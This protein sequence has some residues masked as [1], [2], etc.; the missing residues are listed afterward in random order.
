MQ[1]L[2]ED[3]YGHGA[4]WDIEVDEATRLECF[5]VLFTGIE[6]IERIDLSGKTHVR[7]K[8]TRMRYRAMFRLDDMD[9]IWAAELLLANWKRAMLANNASGVLSFRSEVDGG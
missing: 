8:R 5:T 4:T 2:L 3:R 1:K 7:R 9:P 6:C